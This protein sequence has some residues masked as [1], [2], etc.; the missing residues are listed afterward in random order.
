ML[1]MTGRPVLRLLE[2]PRNDGAEFRFRAVFQVFLNT[3]HVYISLILTSS[4][5]PILP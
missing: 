2:K 4:N 3:V 1:L 5:G